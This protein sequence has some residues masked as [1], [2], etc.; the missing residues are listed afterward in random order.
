LQLVP[1]TD[2][3]A[4]FANAASRKYSMQYYS[5][6]GRHTD[7]VNNCEKL[8]KKMLS[9]IK[10]C[11]FHRFIIFQ[12]HLCDLQVIISGRWTGLWRQ[13]A[14][15][16]SPIPYRAIR[17]ATRPPPTTTIPGTMSMSML[18]YRQC[19]VM[20]NITSL[21]ATSSSLKHARA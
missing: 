19:D 16:D 21:M 13:W 20:M 10:N 2:R 8:S 17:I 18:A 3:Q 14:R 12:L 5:T 6:D 9:F 1:I 15:S 4:T 7:L 11:S